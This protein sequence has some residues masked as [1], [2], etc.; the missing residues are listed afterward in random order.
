MAMTS[1]SWDT[2][3]PAEIVADAMFMLVRAGVIPNGQRLVDAC[4]V[5]KLSVED[6][7]LASTRLDG[8]PGRYLAPSGTIPVRLPDD[9]GD[10]E[11]TRATERRRKSR[12]A[13]ANPAIPSP[14][15][16]TADPSLELPVV[17]ITPRLAPEEAK[18]TCERC[19][20][21]KPIDQFALRGQY[22]ARKCG[23]CEW[24]TGRRRRY[25]AALG[26]ELISR[27]PF[28]LSTHDPLLDGPCAL[29]CGSPLLP[30]EPLV[31]VDVLIAHERC[32]P[33]DG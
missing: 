3:T 15:T 29:L 11:V 17:T 6:V 26:H 33:T 27:Q 32:L 8:N 18:R 31:T 25:E 30:D 19:N 12:L 16:V 9:P 5:V 7:R 23:L 21:S 22:R 28:T 14:L 13:L 2:R 20:R 24:L 1:P 10:P 4:R